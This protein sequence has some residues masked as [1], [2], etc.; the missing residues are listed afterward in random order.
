MKIPLTIC[1]IPVIAEPNMPD[2]HSM[3]LLLCGGQTE[4]LSFP[5][6]DHLPLLGPS[7]VEYCIAPLFLIS[8]RQ[9]LDVS[10]GHGSQ[11]R[12]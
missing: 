11:A 5:I 4:G 2:K 12:A 1:R 6:G 8:N 7:T 3:W 10:R 9:T